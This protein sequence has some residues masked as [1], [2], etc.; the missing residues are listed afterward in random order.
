MSRYRIPRMSMI[1]VPSCCSAGNITNVRGYTA[2]DTDQ[3]KKIHCP[4]DIPNGTLEDKVQCLSYGW[5]SKRDAFILAA[6]MLCLRIKMCEQP[7]NAL[8]RLH[9]EVY[10]GSVAD[11]PG[12]YRWPSK[13]WSMYDR[14]DLK[15][16]KGI[17]TRTFAE[18][19]RDN[20]MDGVTVTT[21]EAPSVHGK[22]EGYNSFGSAKP[23]GYGTMICATICVNDIDAFIAWSEA[24]CDRIL[25]EADIV[26]NK[27]EKAIK[28][29]AMVWSTAI[30]S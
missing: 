12:R 6:V 16:T 25:A 20:Y 14:I 15:N 27:P 30:G 11:E 19:L 24:Q 8:K 26:Y 22:G 10:C 3:Y 9:P 17:N 28:D 13:M 18:F 29:A 1:R 5:H 4:N 21:C 23:N 7:Y 2:P